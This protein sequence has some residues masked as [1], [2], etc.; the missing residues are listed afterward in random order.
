MESLDYFKIREYCRAGLE[1]AD[2][3]G[4]HEGLTFVIG[5]KEQFG[6]DLAFPMKMRSYWT[7]V[8]APVAESETRAAPVHSPCE[9]R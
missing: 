3:E 5:E 7:P 2:T 8:E 1:I 9:G 6:G 4:I